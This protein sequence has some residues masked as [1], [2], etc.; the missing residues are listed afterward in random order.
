MNLTNLLFTKIEKIIS[1]I[2]SEGFKTEINY[3]S[4][5]QRQKKLTKTEKLKRA[6][7]PRYSDRSLSENNKEKLITAVENIFDKLIYSSESNVESLELFLTVNKLVKKE[8]DVR[9]DKLIEIYRDSILSENR[10]EGDYTNIDIKNKNVGI[11]LMSRLELSLRMSDLLNEQLE[12]VCNTLI[13]IYDKE[14][15]C[16]KNLDKVSD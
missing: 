4:R 6:E 16:L 1:D 15:E 2:Q 14:E 8:I 5:P 11:E 9:C 12:S 3:C 13:N 10:E 7:K